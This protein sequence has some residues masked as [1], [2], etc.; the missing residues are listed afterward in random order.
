M[1]VSGISNQRWN[2]SN[3]NG[4]VHRSYYDF[5][6]HIPETSGG[7]GNIIK[8]DSTQKIENV[9]DQDKRIMTQ[10]TYMKSHYDHHGKLINQVSLSFS[11]G[12]MIDL[13]A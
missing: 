13:Y 11:G 4:G 2:F 6:R 10:H 5:E 8:S 7:V 1:N 3:W 12:Y 9:G